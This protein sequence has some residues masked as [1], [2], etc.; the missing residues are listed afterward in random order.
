MNKLFLIT[1]LSVPVMAETIENKPV[2]RTRKNRL[3]VVVGASPNAIN[4]NISGNKT[5]YSLGHKA[6]LGVSYDR[7]YDR[8]SFVGAEILTNGTILLRAGEEF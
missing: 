8:G 1:F 3:A 2:N 4:M 6:V 7:K 5:V